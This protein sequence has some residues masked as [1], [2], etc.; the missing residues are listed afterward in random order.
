MPIGPRGCAASIRFLAELFK[1]LQN[2]VAVR[3]KDGFIQVDSLGRTSMRRVIACFLFVLAAVPA[4]AQTAEAVKPS[5]TMPLLTY[6]GTAAMDY[7]STYYF[8]QFEG[9]QEANPTIKWLDHRPKT[10]L[11]VGAA[12]ETTSIY[13]LYR[14]IGRSH[15]RLARV[16]LYAGSGV[17]FV[18]GLKNYADTRDHRRL[19]PAE[20]VLWARY[21][22]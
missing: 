1:C 20:E 14:W 8:L 3:V 19:S 22:R 13:F 18:A 6:A 21:R 9:M 4:R 12:M 2:R 7:H 11:T 15:P 16:A 10:M 5:L 17:H